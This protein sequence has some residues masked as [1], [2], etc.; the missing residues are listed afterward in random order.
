VASSVNLKAGLQA[1]GALRPEGS[2]GQEPVAHETTVIATGARPGDTA[3]KR[4]L[5][6]EETQ[7]V[8]VFENG[9][10]IRLSAAVADGQLLFLT[11]KAT[12]KEVVAQVLR[13]RAFRPT[14]CYVDLEFTEPCPSFWGIEFAKP[15][16]P[17]AAAKL[18]E[19]GEDSTASAPPP[20]LQEVEKLKEEVAALQNQLKSLQ[21]VDPREEER[22]KARIA[23]EIAAELA[24][25]EE[26]KRLQELFA[27]EKQLDEAQAPKIRVASGIAGSTAEKIKR[28]RNWIIAAGILTVLGLGAAYQFGFLAVYG[29]KPA[30]KP[31]AASNGPSD[32]PKSGAKLPPPNWP[33]SNLAASSKPPANAKPAEA[34]P[35]L[36]GNA[37]SA[38]LAPSATL[39]QP[40]DQPKTS[41]TGER[42]AAQTPPAA[43]YPGSAPARSASPPAVTHKS[44]RLPAPSHA[45]ANAN[46]ASP[47]SSTMQ[48]AGADSEAAAATSSGP[49]YISP[50][51]VKSVKPVSP[52]EVMKNYVTGNVSMDALID[53]TGHVKSVTV[54]SGP[55]KLRAHAI[56]EMQQYV[57]EPARKNGKPVN[58]HVQVS[59]Q[60]WY[61]P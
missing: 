24:K 52:P 51:L 45:L 49:D 37:A 55:A 59:L 44:E 27:L 46:S 36:A 56:E 54:L 38:S 21:E 22:Q 11:N 50:K 17:V 60:Y 57:Y 10:V 29:L 40:S 47:A 41:A 42:F 12:G 28:N 6:T 13:K 8:L 19:E 61:E 18:G 26:E 43:T 14:N 39:S 32:A 35:G 53:V 48:P 58:A 15:T 33:A 7:T 20:D 9:A 25:K 4:D 34:T 1:V 16:G 3:A 30:K 23:K 31:A 5:F 2:T